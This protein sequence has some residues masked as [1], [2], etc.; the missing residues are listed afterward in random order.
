VRVLGALLLALLL[1][2]CGGSEAPPGAMSTTTGDVV[3]LTDL[4]TL[5]NAFAEGTGRPR[6]LLLL[7]PT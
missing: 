4:A 6:V 7:S 1:G 3:E 5:K 2:G